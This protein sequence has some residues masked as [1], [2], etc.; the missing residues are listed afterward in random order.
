ML[1]IFWA[2]ARVLM[3]N[4]LSLSVGT[5]LMGSSALRFLSLSRPLRSF[6]SAR[7]ALCHF[8]AAAVA[9]AA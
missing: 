7:A 1:S 3:L 5:T 2:I 9:A 4:A 6:S 8:A